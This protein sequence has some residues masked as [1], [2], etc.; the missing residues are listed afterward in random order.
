MYSGL[1][2]KKKKKEF[3]NNFRDKRYSDY[4]YQENDD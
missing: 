4:N 2:E 3:P 1:Q